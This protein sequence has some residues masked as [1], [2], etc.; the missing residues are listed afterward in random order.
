MMQFIQNLN[1][2]RFFRYQDNFDGKRVSNLASTLYYLM[3]MIEVFKTPTGKILVSIILALGLACILQMSFKSNNMVI[4][5]EIKHIA[6]FN[7]YQPV[8]FFSI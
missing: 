5:N 6:K 2:A 3:L 7:C 1:E 8:L 4:I